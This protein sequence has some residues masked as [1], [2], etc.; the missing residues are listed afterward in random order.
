MYMKLGNKKQGKKKSICETYLKF[1][2]YETLDF[3]R[4]VISLLRFGSCQNC[5]SSAN[6]VAEMHEKLSSERA[7]RVLENNAHNYEI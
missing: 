3:F 7:F 6:L 1:F 2:N 4:K 5:M